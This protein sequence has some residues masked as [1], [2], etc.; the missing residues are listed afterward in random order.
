MLSDRTLY[1]YREQLRCWIR[2]SGSAVPSHLNPKSIRH[3]VS[4]IPTARVFKV[5]ISGVPCGNIQRSFR[6]VPLH[7]RQVSVVKAHVRQYRTDYASTR[8]RVCGLLRAKSRWGP[9]T[10]QT[11][12]HVQYTKRPWLSFLSLR[13]V[14]LFVRKRSA[15]RIHLCCKYSKI[16]PVRPRSRKFTLSGSL[17]SHPMDSLWRVETLYEWVT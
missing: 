17:T 9:Q 11:R 10:R 15:F 14:R 3:G 8:I 13:T 7:H 2:R 12:I 1:I 6:Q 16:M 4:F 5:M